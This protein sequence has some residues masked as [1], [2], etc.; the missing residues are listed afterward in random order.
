MTDYHLDRLVETRQSTHRFGDADVPRDTVLDI[1][2]HAQQCPSAWNLQPW[3][4][5]ILESEESIEDAYRASYDQEFLLDAATIIVVTGD[6]R[7]DTFAEE[8]LEDAF[9]K[10]YYTRDG[11]DERIDRISGYSDRSDE[12]VT[13]FLCQQTAIVAYQLQL[14]AE[15]HGL[16]SCIVRGFDQDLLAQSL[17]LADH[18][19]PM[20]L[21]PLGEDEETR[22]Q[23]M[24][25]DVR[26]LTKVH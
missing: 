23:K 7:I 24:R 16:G 10:D 26:D 5:H 18:E 1:L 6:E 2:D 21:V 25:K 3:R 13:G 11:V 22:P 20:F 4:F 8:A 12:F 19:R 15:A 14:S 9:Q 17:D